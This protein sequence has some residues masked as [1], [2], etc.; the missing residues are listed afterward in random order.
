MLYSVRLL[1]H[2]QRKIVSFFKAGKMGLC[3]S[4]HVNLFFI[5]ANLHCVCLTFALMLDGRSEVIRKTQCL[6]KG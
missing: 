4:A 6:H 1:M 3:L 5:T 2:A